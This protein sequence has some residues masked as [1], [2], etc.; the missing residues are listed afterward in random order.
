MFRR[1][2][3]TKISA[4]RM[5]SATSCVFALILIGLI[6]NAGAVSS[7]ALPAWVC[8]KPDAI[9]IHGFE[10]AIAVPH[11]PSLGS[12]GGYP[13]DTS[14]YIT[15]AGYATEPYYIH[16][17]ANYN[18]GRAMPLLIVLHGYAGSH[19][20]A[21]TA[22]QIISYDWGTI[23]DTNGFIVIAPVGENSSGSWTVPPSA[24]PTDYDI[25]AT[26][27]TDALSAYNIDR[28]RTY[29]WGFSAGGY[30][31]FDLVLNNYNSV[32][33]ADVFAAYSA[34][35]GEMLGFACGSSTGCNQLLAAQARRVPVDMHVGTMDSP[36]L[37][38][39]QADHARLLSHG[40]VDGS[41]VFYT[42][43]NGGH[44]YTGQLAGAWQSVCGF[45]LTP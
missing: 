34:N 32:V 10:S 2:H 9:F 23:A 4:I 44:T 19:N 24:G 27:F 20:D 33:N 22:A 26:A 38:P 35:S 45:A 8:A 21:D 15:V 36:H 40:W 28:S 7:V 17:P 39:A 29:L 25:I 41:T 43:F 14:R 42:E 16:I 5:R 1:I 3:S 11:N 31:A 13:G 18:P 37:A 30:V 6:A 12:G